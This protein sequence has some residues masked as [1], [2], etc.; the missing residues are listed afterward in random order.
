MIYKK[1]GG[2]TAEVES[3]RESASAGT[4]AERF[5][6]LDAHRGFIMRHIVRN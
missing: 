3:I 4:M 6:A 5:V 1:E 2:E